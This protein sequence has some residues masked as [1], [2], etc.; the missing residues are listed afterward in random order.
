MV[1]K[2]AA[3]IQSYVTWMIYFQKEDL[4]TFLDN[5]L[6][7]LYKKQNT[8]S[9]SNPSEQFLHICLKYKFKVVSDTWTRPGYTLVLNLDKLEPVAQNLSIS[10]H[11]H[12]ITITN[13][14][15]CMD[16]NWIFSIRMKTMLVLYRQESDQFKQNY[17]TAYKWWLLQI[18]GTFSI[19]MHWNLL[20]GSCLIYCWRA[21]LVRDTSN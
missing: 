15:K 17:S 21:N 18:T 9:H 6:T 8:H 2:L 10:L 11:N 14:L 7:T 20:P 12:D 4:Q 1:K 16:I 5:C 19:H 3:G 13:Y